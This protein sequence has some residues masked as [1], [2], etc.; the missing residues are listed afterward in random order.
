MNKKFLLGLIIG[1]FVFSGCTAASSKEVGIENNQYAAKSGDASLTRDTAFIDSVAW[2]QDPNQATPIAILIKGSLPTSCHQLRVALTQTDKELQF[3]VYS[4]APKDSMCAQ[5][6]A[7]FEATLTLANLSGSDY[8]VIV[9][10][11]KKLP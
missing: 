1:I 4:V 8:T 5:V 3:E 6:L 11:E 7:P 9:N 2:V 10:G